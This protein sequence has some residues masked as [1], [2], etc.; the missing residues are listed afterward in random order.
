METKTENGASDL[1]AEV[2]IPIHVHEYK[3]LRTESAADLQVQVNKFAFAGGWQMFGPAQVATSKAST[4]Y[5]A[6]LFKVFKME[7]QN[8]PN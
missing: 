2:Q 5:V 8:V 3:I 4:V 1:L 7:N 6:T